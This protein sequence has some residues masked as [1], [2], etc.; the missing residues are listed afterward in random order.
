MLNPAIQKTWIYGLKQVLNNGKKV[1][2]A[3]SGFG[4]PISSLSAEDFSKEGYFYQMGV[5]PARIDILMSV[6]GVNFSDAWK[7]RESGQF[8][9]FSANFVS[10]KDLIAMK[11]IAGRHQDLADIEV[12]ELV[13]EDQ[14]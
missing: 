8:A 4:A 5:P 13:G 12:L 2:K 1:Y 6:K 9:G 11:K 7:R 14:G 3:L 10:R